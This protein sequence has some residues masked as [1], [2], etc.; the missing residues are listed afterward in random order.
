MCIVVMDICNFKIVNEL[1]GTNAGDTLLVGI[2]EHLKKL[3]A[4]DASKKVEEPK[5]E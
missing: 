5:A 2:A 1:Y 3:D 4:K